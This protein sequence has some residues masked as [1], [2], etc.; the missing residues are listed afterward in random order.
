MEGHKKGF[1]I[2]FNAIYSYLETHVYQL[3]FFTFWIESYKPN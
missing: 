3:L 1:N 2:L